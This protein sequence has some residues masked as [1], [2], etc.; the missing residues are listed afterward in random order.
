MWGIICWQRA[1]SRRRGFPE[2]SVCG[3]YR[4]LMEEKGDICRQKVSSRRRKVSSVTG[5]YLL[6]Q[7]NICWRRGFFWK[8]SVTSVGGGY[9]LVEEG[10]IYW[11]RVYLLEEGNICWWR[12]SSGRRG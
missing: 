11:R 2:T 7:V 12:V 4:H 10:N 6:E 8:K 9:L 5:G 1:S 3:E